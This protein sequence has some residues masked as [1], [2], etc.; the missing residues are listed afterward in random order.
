VRCLP[1]SPWHVIEKLYASEIN[2]GLET[3]WDGG[4]RVWIGSDGR[5]RLTEHTFLRREFDEVAAWLDHE[6]R[7]LFPD[8]KYARTVR[9][10]ER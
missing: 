2:A 7:R 6:A 10:A 8:S 1:M 9:A 4:L 5:Y 3:D